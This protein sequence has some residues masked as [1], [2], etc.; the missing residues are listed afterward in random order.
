[1]GQ[2]K[3]EQISSGE[4]PGDK[5]KLGADVYENA[6]KFNLRLATQGPA[7]LYALSKASEHV[8]KANLVT[9][10]GGMVVGSIGFFGNRYYRK[11][12]DDTAYS[13]MG[14]LV[15]GVQFVAGFI[16]LALQAS[17]IYADTGEASRLLAVIQMA[18][19]ALTI[20]EGALVLVNSY[21]YSD[22]APKV[23]AAGRQ[24]FD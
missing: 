21:L 12:G 3:R 6:A 1:M 20:T 23:S 11:K 13:Y 5:D 14:Q 7:L 22:G 9:G 16:L 2:E 8:N 10:I 17:E 4:L 18:A 24:K 15:G 19:V